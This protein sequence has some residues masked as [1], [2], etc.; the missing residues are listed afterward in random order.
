MGCVKELLPVNIYDCI[1]YMV[2]GFLQD[3]GKHRNCSVLHRKKNSHHASV[4]EERM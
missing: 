1:M 3:D 4:Y 2:A